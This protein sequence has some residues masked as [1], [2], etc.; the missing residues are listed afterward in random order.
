MIIT[1]PSKAPRLR[2]AEIVKEYFLEAGFTFK[3]SQLEFSKTEKNRKII[4][5]LFFFKTSSLVRASLSWGIVFP[6]LE[7]IWK[8]IGLD[9]EENGYTVSLWTDLLNYFPLRKTGI[10]IS[11][12]MFSEETFK[13]DDISLNNAG[14][15]II[16][17]Y[18]R[19]IVPYFEFYSKLSNLEKEM[20]VLPLHHHSELMYGG[21]QIAFG[22][23]LRKKFI[24]SEFD[25]L[26]NQ[27]QEYIVNGKEGEDFKKTMLVYLERTVNFLKSNDIEALLSEQ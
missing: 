24:P 12:K 8:K 9:G 5:R 13:Y 2:L 25:K 26:V 18:E 4:V 16:A 6:E 19:Y 3:K 1:D 11:I 21:R 10:P 23:A 7:K 14:E 20:N 17:N 22:L 27:Y 15:W